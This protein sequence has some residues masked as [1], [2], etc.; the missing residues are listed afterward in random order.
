MSLR[1]ERA[2]LCRSEHQSMWR[3]HSRKCTFSALNGG[4]RTPSAYS[5]V[6]CKACMRCWRTKAGYVAGLPDLKERS[7]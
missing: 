5:L 4:R 2:A 3:V 1:S 6:M 7:S